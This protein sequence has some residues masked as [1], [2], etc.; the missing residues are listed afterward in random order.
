MSNELLSE[1]AFINNLIET[2]KPITIFLKSGIK[3]IGIVTGVD[4][5]CIFLKNIVTQM[6]YKHAISTVVPARAVSL[7][8][9]DSQEK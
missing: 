7:Q 2:K 4:E 5:H 1:E 6:V 8:A 3:L 9:D